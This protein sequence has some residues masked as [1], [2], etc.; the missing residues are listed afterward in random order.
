[1]A[2]DRSKKVG[3]TTRLK[4]NNAAGNALGA[5]HMAQLAN[6][7][8]QMSNAPMNDSGM[9]RVSGLRGNPAGLKTVSAL[10]DLRQL[11]WKRTVAIAALDL[12]TAFSGVKATGAY[13]ATGLPTG[14]AIAANT[15]ILTGTPSTAGAGTAVITVLAANGAYAPISVSLPWVIASTLDAGDPTVPDAA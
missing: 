1:M 8:P 4:I 13:S 9:Y 5:T 7:R 2:M 3:S 6:G 12:S 15:G 10:P 11:G 14:V